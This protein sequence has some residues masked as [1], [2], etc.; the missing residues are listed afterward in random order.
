MHMHKELVLDVMIM[1][2]GKRIR[3]ADRSMKKV[4]CMVYSGS[5]S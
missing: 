5:N 4:F 1:L 2:V 3:F